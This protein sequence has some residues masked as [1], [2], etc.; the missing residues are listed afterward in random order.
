MKNL[1]IITDINFVFFEYRLKLFKDLK[2]KWINIFVFQKSNKK[3]QNTENG[4]L[5]QNFTNK[6]DLVWEIKKIWNI[7]ENFITTFDEHMII[8]LNEIKKNLNQKFVEHYEA[9]EDKNLQ[10]KLLLNF[11]PT[12]T[13]NYQQIKNLKEKIN[14]DY[15]YIIKPVRWVQSRGV[16]L[17]K[18][19]DDLE[20]YIKTSFSVIENLSNRWYESDSFIVE[21]YIDWQTRSVAFFVDWNWNI[22]FLDCVFLQTAKDLWIDDFSIVSRTISFSKIK[23]IE[24]KD[25]ENFVQKNVKAMWI[26]DAFIHHEFKLNSKWI[27][28]TIELNWRIGW[29]RLDMYDQAFWINMFDMVFD[30]WNFEKQ[31]LKNNLS[32][33]ALQAVNLWKFVWIDEEIVQKIRKLKSFYKL[34]IVKK[35]LNTHTWPAKDGFTKVWY[36]YLKNTDEKQFQQDYEFVKNNYKKILKI[37]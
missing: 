31:K 29:F 6:Q 24:Q 16:S 19:K 36:L 26:K 5:L 22:K 11:D 9:F 30:S 27:L 33:F 10:R 18:N 35:Y 12:I 21:E 2:E 20:N 8:F 34:H 17:I 32:V 4:V 28:K 14:L 3:R 7:Q 37:I 1:I 25:L 23:E 13:V 15:P